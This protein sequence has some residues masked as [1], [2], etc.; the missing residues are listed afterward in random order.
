MVD[1]S[2]IAGTVSALKGAADILKTMI[3]L[4]DAKAMDSKIIELNAMILDAQR[5]AFTANDER[6]SLIEQISALEKEVVRLKDWTAEKEEYEFS[7]VSL[8]V[9]AYV[10]KPGMERAKKPHML[11]ANCYDQG[12]RGVLQSTHEVRRGRRVH[13]CSRCKEEYELIGDRFGQGTAS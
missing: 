9:Y 10:P 7:E 8:R 11:C 13:R 2:A 12:Q 4:H 3:G 1:M 5:S 6:A